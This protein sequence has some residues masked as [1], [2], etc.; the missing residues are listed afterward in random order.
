MVHLWTGI[1]LG[2]YLRHGPK[3]QEAGCIAIGRVTSC[4]TRKG[5]G[6]KGEG[7]IVGIQAEP[8]VAPDGA[9]G[10]ASPEYKVSMAAPQVNWGVPQGQFRIPK[11]LVAFQN[12][13]R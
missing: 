1:P 12:N 8:T 11:R 2:G 13:Q 5:K 4:E 9:A 10:A 3:P 6:R 7:D